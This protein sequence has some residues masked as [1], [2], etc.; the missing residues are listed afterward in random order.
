MKNSLKVLKSVDYTTTSCVLQSYIMG[1]L[2]IMLFIIFINDIVE[3]IDANYLYYSDDPKMFHRFKNFS[4]CE[5]RKSIC[6]P[7]AM[8]R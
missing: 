4:D 6:A 2:F 5:R 7:I 1:I 8:G 3:L